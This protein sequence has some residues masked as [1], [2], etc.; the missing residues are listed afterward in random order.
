MSATHRAI[1]KLIQ[2]ARQAETRHRQGFSGA[3]N[4]Q[5]KHLRQLKLIMKES[6]HGRFFESVAITTALA[7]VSAGVVTGV[8]GALM[9]MGRFAAGSA[10]AVTAARIGRFVSAFVVGGVSAAAQGD[11]ASFVLG[12]VASPS[13]KVADVFNALQM[14]LTAV[15]ESYRLASADSRK[16]LERELDKVDWGSHLSLYQKHIVGNAEQ[17][18]RA[19]V[20]HA[21]GYG[22]DAELH[23]HCAD[24]LQGLRKGAEQVQAKLGGP[25]VRVPAKEHF[26]S[27][28]TNSTKITQGGLIVRGQDV[29][30]NIYSH[31]KQARIRFEYSLTAPPPRGGHFF[32]NRDDRLTGVAPNGYQAW[33]GGSSRGIV[34]YDFKGLDSDAHRGAFSFEVDCYQASPRRWIGKLVIAVR[35]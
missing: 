23:L 8:R 3:R 31:G 27:G 12:L 30:V 33:K 28:G 21:Q 16:E 5:R 6:S 9:G 2:Q 18:L 34:A 1:Q 29:M 11:P 32:V 17:T 4:E 22:L 13:E 19:T 35:R 15:E 10:E 25:A 26:S 7:A 24:C 20:G 14:A